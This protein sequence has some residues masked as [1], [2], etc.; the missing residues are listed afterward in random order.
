MSRL[1]V[2]TSPIQQPQLV[3]LNPIEEQPFFALLHQMVQVILV[4]VQSIEV[5]MP[6]LQH[7]QVSVLLVL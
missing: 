3:E 4:A 6:L 7:C 1:T 5:L 2:S